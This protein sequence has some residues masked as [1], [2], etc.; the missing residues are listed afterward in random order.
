[1]NQTEIREIKNL[2]HNVVF[3]ALVVFHQ[4]E[5]DALF[6]E[7]DESFSAMTKA[8]CDYDLAKNALDALN[9][10]LEAC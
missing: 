10:L 7:T 9:L 5:K 6:N 3:D 2:L 4:A 8:R 1:M